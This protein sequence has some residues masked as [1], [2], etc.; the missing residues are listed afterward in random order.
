VSYSESMTLSVPKTKEL[1]D[2]GV[3]GLFQGQDSG[4]VQV[5]SCG[6]V[7]ELHNTLDL[8]GP[9]HFVSPRF[10]SGSFHLHL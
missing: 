4:G 5:F 9:T 10:A 7:V 2:N 3:A 8:L 6:R 1:V